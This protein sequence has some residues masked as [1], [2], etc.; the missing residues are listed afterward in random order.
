M[1]RIVVTVAILFDVL[2]TAGPA[3][4]AT[5]DYIQPPPPAEQICAQA[6]TTAAYVNAAWNAGLIPYEATILADFSTLRT[7]SQNN[8][9][10][11]AQA[12]AWSNAVNT[13]IADVQNG[14]S[15]GAAEGAYNNNEQNMSNS[16]IV[17]DYP[18]NTYYLGII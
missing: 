11:Q 10:F 13:L 17:R 3:R 12:L 14:Q 4:A 8:P 16:C 1:K 7:L 15:Y 18:F 6:G 5:P 9:P 2:L